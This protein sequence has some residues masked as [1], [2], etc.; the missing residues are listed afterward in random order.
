MATS[1]SAGI[2]AAGPSTTHAVLKRQS[3]TRLTLIERQIAEL[4]AESGG[5]KALHDALYMP[6]LVA[7][8]FNLCFKAK[9]TQ[10]RDAGKQAKVTIVAIMRM[11]LETANTLV[12]ADRLWSIKAPCA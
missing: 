7:M 1:V 12:K 6:A 3:Q 9:Y 2:A 11:L 4:D 10:L 8:R 5:R